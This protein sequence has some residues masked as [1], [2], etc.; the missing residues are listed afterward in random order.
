MSEEVFKVTEQLTADETLQAE[1][2][3]D[4]RKFLSD[5]G[6]PV[7]LA[8][9]LLPTLMAVVAAGGV[10]LQQIVPLSPGMGWR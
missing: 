2:M 4:P 8:E 9:R 7:E 5:R 10:V 1:F 6:V 3:A